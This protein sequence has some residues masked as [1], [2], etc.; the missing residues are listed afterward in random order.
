[1][2]YFIPGELVQIKHPLMFRPQMVVKEVKKS[3]MKGADGKPLLLGIQCF[4]FTTTG[5]YSEIMFNSKDLE[6]VKQE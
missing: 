1:M 6:R 4:W 5:V 3:R 2:I